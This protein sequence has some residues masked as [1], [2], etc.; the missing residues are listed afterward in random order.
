MGQ[1]GAKVWKLNNWEHSGDNTGK[2]NQE[3]S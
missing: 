1:D 3:E 2:G